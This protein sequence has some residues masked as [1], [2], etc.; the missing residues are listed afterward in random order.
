MGMVDNLS[1][2]IQRSMDYFESQ[3]RQAP[4]K[5]IYL[6]IDT[7]HQDE[8]ASMIKEII[9]ISVDKFVPKIEREQGLPLTPACLASLGAAIVKPG[10][11]VR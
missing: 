2:E 9:F 6:I 5:S 1:L 10:L 8:L 3:L 11:S 7:L 4:I